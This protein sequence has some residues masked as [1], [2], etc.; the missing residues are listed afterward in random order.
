MIKDARGQTIKIRFGY[1]NWIHLVE[2]IYCGV[3]D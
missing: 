1:I 2:G 3:N